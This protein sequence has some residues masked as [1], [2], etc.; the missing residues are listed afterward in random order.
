[1]LLFWRNRQAAETDLERYS[2]G[3]GYEKFWPFPRGCT[4]YVRNR[5]SKMYED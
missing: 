4:G 5:W 1:V 2:Q 3:G